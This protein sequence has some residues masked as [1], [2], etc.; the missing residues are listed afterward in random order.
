MSESFFKEPIKVDREIDL[1]GD[2][3]PITFVKSKLAIEEIEVGQVLR[4][5]IDYPGSVTN[6]PRSVA[7]EGH[8]ILGVH[9]L[10]ERLWEILIEKGE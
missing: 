9:T 7:N 4:V 2:V 6:V 1:R 8:K 10:A 5:L 3:C